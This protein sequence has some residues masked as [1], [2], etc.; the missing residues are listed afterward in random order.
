MN[1]TTT[2]PTPPA[3]P[4]KWRTRE[5]QWLR[6]AQMTTTHLFYTLRMI[7]NHTMPAPAQLPGGRY[8]FG[9][10]YTEEYM[11]AAIVHVTTELAR[12]DDLP[13]ELGQQL[14][15]MINWLRTHQVEGIELPKL[16]R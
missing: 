8:N 12:R 2:Q 5:G 3:Q 1:L 11:K 9:A 13:R 10:Y 15:H 7:W 4:W 16:L 14:K 6:P